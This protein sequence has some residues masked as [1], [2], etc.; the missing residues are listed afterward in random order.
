MKV[1]DLTPG[2]R[3]TNHTGTWVFIGQ[4]PHPLFAGLKLVVWWKDGPEVD[5]C[6]VDQYSFDALNPSQVVPGQIELWDE[7]V[8]KKNL[9]RA[10]I[11]G[12]R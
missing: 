3:V 10:L 12:T 9:L 11:P 1:S 4:M 7:Q 5:Q 6:S 2:V 8:L